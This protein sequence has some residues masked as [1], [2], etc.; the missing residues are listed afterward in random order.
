MK[1]RYTLHALERMRQRGV[2]RGEVEACLSNPDKILEDKESKCVK[3][4]KR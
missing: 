2:S 1:T 4:T 3:E